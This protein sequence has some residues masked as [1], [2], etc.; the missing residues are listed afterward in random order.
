MGSIAFISFS[1]IG[2]GIRSLDAYLRA[3]GLQSVIIFFSQKRRNHVSQKEAELIVS[4]LRQNNTELAGISVVSSLFK[5]ASYL[6]PIIQKGVNVP[7]IFG[8]AYPTICPEDCLEIADFVCIGEGE[9]ALID[10]ANAIGE[11]SNFKNIPNIWGFSGEEIWR[12]P[13]RPLISDVNSL[14]LLSMDNDHKYIIMNEKLINKDPLKLS[15]MYI[16]RISR[17]CRFSCGY[18][19]NQTLRRITG[20]SEHYFRMRSPENVIKELLIA[21]HAI[22]GLKMIKMDEVFDWGDTPWL[23]EFSQR[24]VIEKIALP[25]EIELYP[26]YFDKAVLDL[27]I[28]TGLKRVTIGVESGSEEIRSSVFKRRGANVQFLSVTKYLQSKGVQLRYNFISDN[29]FEDEDDRKMGLDLLMEL[30]RAYIT[31]VYNLK[32][33]PK[34]FIADEALAKGLI[35]EN[36]LEGKG[37]RKRLDWKSVVDQH[38]F[39]T[40]RYYASLMILASKRYLPRNVTRFITRLNL[41]HNH[42]GILIYTLKL[43]EYI[44]KIGKWLI[45]Q[46]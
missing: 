13:S 7:V 21:K 44:E 34:T 18:C 5:T 29:P 9:G 19:S 6:A 46:K 26:G 28:K 4:I 10:L 1:A 24:Y 30:P 17:G 15:S 45:G 27:L 33:Y 40:D 23:E 31:K 42:K 38:R 36:D 25:L 3:N 41:F 8:G 22:K 39:D 35:S 16:I 14:P 32:F 2:Y 37:P 43:V 11:N 20:D 12:N